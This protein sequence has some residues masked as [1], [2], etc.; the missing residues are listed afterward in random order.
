MRQKTQQIVRM[1]EMQAKKDLLNPPEE[2]YPLIKEFGQSVISLV[3]FIVLMYLF[4]VFF[5]VPQQ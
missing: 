5:S 4:M 2:K 3:L 1:I